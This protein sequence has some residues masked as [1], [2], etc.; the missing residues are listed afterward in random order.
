MTTGRPTRPGGRGWIPR[1][2]ARTAPPSRPSVRARWSRADRAASVGW[3]VLSAS[4]WARLLAPAAMWERAAWLTDRTAF[5]APPSESSTNALTGHRTDGAGDRVAVRPGWCCTMEEVVFFAQI[6]ARLQV[7]LTCSVKSFPRGTSI[8][9]VYCPSSPSLKGAYSI[10][11]SLIFFKAES[12]LELHCGK[13][14]RLPQ[15]AIHFSVDSME[16]A[17]PEFPEISK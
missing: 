4:S 7:L 1:M 6:I 13:V 14:A 10:S 15:N 16:L 11:I 17:R 9:I 8:A 3:G 5:L 12:F 2:P